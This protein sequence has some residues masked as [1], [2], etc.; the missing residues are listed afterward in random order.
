[1][2]DGQ[3]HIEHGHQIGWRADRFAN[4]PA[5][6]IER[7]LERPWGARTA[8]A[9]IREHEQCYPVVDN[10]A[11]AGAGLTRALAA[12]GTADF[13]ATAPDLLCPE[14]LAPC[15]RFVRIDPY[16]VTPAAPASATGAGGGREL[17][18]GGGL[19]P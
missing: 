15:Y 10:F 13:G 7:A 1:M 17:R 19:R 8:G 14:H 12:A 4:W 9:L 11:D 5:P 2:A 16:E 3:E 18:A 6:F